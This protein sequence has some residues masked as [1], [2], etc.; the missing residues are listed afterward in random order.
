MSLV[1]P[2]EYEFS[3]DGQRADPAG[4]LSKLCLRAIHKTRQSRGM[5]DTGSMKITLASISVNIFKLFICK[6]SAH[7]YDELEVHVHMQQPL[8]GTRTF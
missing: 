6:V 5:D 7:S 3:S 2:P 8:C 4:M 1:R